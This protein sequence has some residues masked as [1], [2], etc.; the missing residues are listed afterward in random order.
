MA[1]S[2]VVA[3]ASCN[4]EVTAEITPNQPFVAKCSVGIGVGN[5]HVQ[6]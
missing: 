3:I 4:Q 1:L 2:R 5:H 6:T